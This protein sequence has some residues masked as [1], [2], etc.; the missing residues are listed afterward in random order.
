MFFLWLCDLLVLELSQF[1]FGGNAK[2]VNIHSLYIAW[3][4]KEQSWV[5]SEES[6]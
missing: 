5:S 1:I 2:L 6:E 3:A 4:D